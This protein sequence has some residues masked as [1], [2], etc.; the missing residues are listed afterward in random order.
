M[1]PAPKPVSKVLDDVKGAVQ[2]TIT[3]VTGKQPPTG[4]TYVGRNAVSTFDAPSTEDQQAV[5]TPFVAPISLITN[6]LNAAI[7]PFIN[8]TPGQPAPQNPI[9][10]AVLGWVRRQ[11]QDTPFGKIVLNQTPEITTPE[12]VDNHDGTF[13]ITPSSDDVDPDGDSL[14]YSATDGEDGSVVKNTDGTFTYTVDAAN[15]DKSDTITLTASDE[16]AYPHIHGLAGLFSPNGGHTDSIVVNI[17]P[18]EDA[19]PPVVNDGTVKDVKIGDVAP[20]NE[21]EAIALDGQTS[22]TPTGATVTYH[23]DP[24]TNILT[25]DVNPSMRTVWPAS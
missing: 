14:S 22:T 6:V 5:R 1:K 21:D 4:S 23:Y 7:A 12:V 8:T 24:D 25:A 16:G 18:N 13:T 19:G 15:W 17:A 3:E 2:Q 9:L 10:W 11:V 20:E